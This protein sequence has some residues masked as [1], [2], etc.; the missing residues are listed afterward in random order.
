MWLDLC[1][2]PVLLGI[3]LETWCLSFKIVEKIVWDKIHWTS[4]RWWFYYQSRTSLGVIFFHETA[5]SSSPQFK[6]H[7]CASPI[8]HTPAIPPI[9]L[10]LSGHHGVVREFL[11]AQCFSGRSWVDDSQS[12]RSPVWLSAHRN[13]ARW[14][15]CCLLAF[16]GATRHGTSAVSR[17]A[18]QAPSVLRAWAGAW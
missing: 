8:S 13:G 7:D 14:G 12:L 5:D 17:W 2:V 6:N 10:P 16:S 3:K 1:C 4:S 15:G 9:Y 18:E 11:G